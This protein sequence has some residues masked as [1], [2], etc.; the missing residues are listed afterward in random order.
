MDKIN[1]GFVGLGRIADVHYPGY[2]NNEYAKLYAICDTNEE[3]LMKRKEQ[4]NIEKTY[5]NYKEMLEDK[6]LDAVEILTPQLY[7]EKMV[8]DSALAKKHIAVQKPMTVDLKSADRMIQATKEAGVIFK[9][10]DNYAFYPPLIFAKELIESGKIG[11][12][13]NIRIKFTGGG[14]GGWDVPASAWKWRMKEKEEGRGL[15]TFDHGHH[16]WTTAW[17]LLGNIERVKGW[18]DTLDG[19]IDCPS[20][21]IWKYKDKMTYGVCEFAQA[22]DMHIPSKYYANDEWMEITGT[23]GIIFIHRCT[24]NIHDGPV[25][26]LFDGHNW[27]RYDDIVCDWGEGFKGS[28]QNFID[29]IRG[30]AKPMLSGE[31]GR[32]ILRFALS[33][34]KSSR[35]RREVYLDE[36]DAKNPKKYTKNRIKQD[37]EKKSKKSGLLDLLGFGKK[38]KKF[39]PH[40]EKLTEQL[41]ENFNPELVKD[42]NCT[43]GLYLLSE[44]QSNEAKYTFKIENGKLNYEKGKLPENFDIVLEVPKGIWAMILLRKKRLETAFLQGKIKIK[45][46]IEEALKLRSALGI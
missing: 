30:E 6:N 44:G 42:W 4:W 37:I 22:S 29:S 10:T 5:T 18:I 39:A 8:I 31:Q 14:S 9:V 36:M 26:S 19:L 45:G 43:V 46:K 16:L 28:T 32:E 11:T 3:Y 23:E 7:H 27:K 34:Q 2:I 13:T 25:I 33:I 15:Q 38:S 40:S 24:G 17:Y 1:V 21:V 35:C 41:I 20:V 12:P